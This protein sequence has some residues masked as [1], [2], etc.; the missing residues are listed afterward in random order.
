[1]YNVSQ[2]LVVAGNKTDFVTINEAY[3][4]V[5]GEKFDLEAGP[6]IH[7]NEGSISLSV[8]SSRTSSLDIYPDIKLYNRSLSGKFVLDKTLDKVI[9]KPKISNELNFDLSNLYNIPGVYEGVLVF[10]DKNGN[11]IS[12]EADFRFI[13]EG[14]VVTIHKVDLNSSSF[15]KGDKILVSFIYTGNP[16]TANATSTDIS[17]TTMIYKTIVKI[18]DEKGGLVAEKE[19]SIDFNKGIEETVQMVS[20]EDAH[21]VSVNIKILKNDGSVLTEYNE[22]FKGSGVNPENIIYKYVLVGILI[23]LIIFLFWLAS[24]FMKKRVLVVVLF[25]LMFGFQTASATTY[26]ALGTATKNGYEAI[27]WIPHLTAFTSPRSVMSPGEAFYVSGNVDI[28]GCTNTNGARGSLYSS[29]IL[30]VSNAPASSSPAEYSSIILNDVQGVSGILTNYQKQALYQPT[31]FY[32]GDNSETEYPAF[33][34]VYRRVGHWSE[35]SSAKFSSINQGFNSGDPFATSTLTQRQLLTYDQF[36]A[37]EEPGTYRIYLYLVGGGEAGYLWGYLEFTV[38][39]T[40]ALTASCY[41]SPNPAI[42]NNTNVIWTA[43][44]T[45]GI[46]S[47][48]YL[49]SGTDN[50]ISGSSS[51]TKTYTATGTKLANVLVTSGAATTSVSCFGSVTS[52]GT[53]NGGCTSNCGIN[54]TSFNYNGVC[55]GTGPY[56]S[57][58]G[59]FCISG[60]LENLSGASDGSWTWN[61][62]GSD[63]STTTDDAIGCRASKDISTPILDPFFNCTSLTNNLPSPV[64]I[65]VNTIWTANPADQCPSCEKEW[66]VVDSNNPTA[67]FVSG[68]NQWNEIF[69][70]IGQKEIIYKLSTT[71]STS[72]RYGTCTATTTVVQEG[73]S[74]NEQ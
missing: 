20:G 55:I 56:E 14:N 27:G 25:A 12:P 3:I 71:T 23:I 2:P 66:A 65:N 51:V 9:L 15:V 42:V 6:A 24:H 30:K 67:V 32:N 59:V 19:I 39:E 4:D 10:K 61:C 74:T 8:S 60:D 18:S 62:L 46:G 13:I 44:S 38:E 26:E 48:T 57:K 41:G 47:Y 58:P 72:T 73:G 70:T 5:G 63:N 52:G 35:Y 36:V 11:A 17:S 45:G 33:N 28:L 7:K 50:L 21:G 1:L 68:T 64:N 69:T 53:P 34:Q 43:T 22:V 31:S 37:P 40:S 49:W 29:P 54:I 16:P